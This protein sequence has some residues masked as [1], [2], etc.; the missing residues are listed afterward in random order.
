MPNPLRF[1][2]ALMGGAT[3]TPASLPG[4]ILWVK[5]DAGLFQDSAFTTPATADTDPVG[6]WRDQSG[7]GNH[8]TQTT[9]GSRPTLKLAIQNGRSVLRLTAASSQFMDLAGLVLNQPASAA[10]VASV[11]NTNGRLLEAVGAVNRRMF[12]NAIA[13]SLLRVHSGASVDLSVDPSVFTFK[14]AVW[15]GVSSL[16]R[17]SASVA[18]G[19]GGAND[20]TGIRVGAGGAGSPSSFMTGDIGEIAYYNR[21]LS[22]SELTQLQDYFKSRWGTA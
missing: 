1:R 10:M 13:T 19:D 17:Q 6:G 5:T 3:F 2:R 11:S 9:A 7:Q 12:Q 20:S 8:L 4:L 22:N 14:A 18:T 16:C 21:A 15:N